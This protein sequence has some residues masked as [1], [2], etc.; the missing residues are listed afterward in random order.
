MGQIL[1]LAIFVIA[2]TF[3]EMK[4][5][6]AE[7][8]RA[9]DQYT[10]ANEPIS[11]IDLMERAAASLARWIMERFPNPEQ[12]FVVFAGAGNN[13]GDGLAVARLLSDSGYSVQAYFVQTISTP[14]PEAVEN[15]KRLTPSDRLRV[16]TLTPE[17]MA[18]Y[19]NP[20]SIIVDALFGSGVNR[21]LEGF[22]AQIVDYINSSG[23][24]IIAVDMPS[25]LMSEDNSTNDYNAIIKAAITLTLELPK[26][27]L[28][29][30]E[31]DSYVGELNIV[32]IGLHPKALEGFPSNMFYVTTDMVA[33]MLYKRRRFA[34]KGTFGH[35]YLVAGSQSMLG[36]A[37]LASQACMRTGSGLLTAHIPAGTQLAFNVTT[38]E[39]ILE[40]DDSPLCF[41][42]HSPLTQ[43][44]AIGVGPG[45][46]TTAAVSEALAKL[47]VDARR[48]PLVIDADA[49]NL[50]ASRKELLK[51]IPK[52][53]ILTPHPKEFE[54]LAG[55]WNTDTEKINRLQQL[56]KELGVYVVLKGANTTISSPDGKLWFSSV[57]NPGM[58][59]AGSGDVLTGII[60]SL[61]GQG[62]SP[63]EASIL[64]VYLHGLAGDIA[65]SKLGQE[66][67]IASDIISNLGEAYKSLWSKR[68]L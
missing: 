65:A 47:L 6:P 52:F 14:T 57:G 62:Y 64:G 51:S 40:P 3:L 10:I 17:S 42:Q 36:A 7:L 9:I 35:C 8:I 20:E 48:M 1:S 4:I 60:L 56:T 24:S 67:L 44:D 21:P 30:P 27:A 58:A 25:G 2:R 19:L 26:L 13:G 63:E 33:Q 55:S 68:F 37:L 5:F 50:I 43:F 23:C 16:E 15:Y 53:A 18:P 49:L 61:L 45:L 32:P 34:H 39:V 28:L 12:E 38:P 59:T 46:G 41:T 29:L 22:N 66:A 11:S 54:R 31:N